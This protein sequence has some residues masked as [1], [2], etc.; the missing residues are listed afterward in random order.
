MSKKKLVSLALACILL[1]ALAVPAFAAGDN[2]PDVSTGNLQTVI[3]ANYQPAVI[4]VSVPANITAVLNPLGLPVEATK[5][6]GVGKVSIEDQQ[7]VLTSPLYIA[8][9][10]KVDLK[11]SIDATTAVEGLLKLAA[12]PFD[13]ATAT[14]NQAYVQLQTLGTGDAT[15]GNLYDAATWMS[16]PTPGKVDDAVL[17]I[18]ANN[19]LW[20]SAESAVL[21]TGKVTFKPTTVLKKAASLYQAE[22]TPGDVSA[23][24]ADATSG[25]IEFAY[26]AGSIMIIRLTGTMAA[27][28]TKPWSNEI[29]PADP[30]LGTDAVAADKLTTTLVF[31]FTPA[32]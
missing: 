18:L 26:G 12:E 17:N 19:S 10:S 6:N 30:N 16:D 2:T 15:S 32:A 22:I 21:K 31:T 8:N 5:S 23:G 9:L 11:V 1:V 24:I 3:T 4:S 13:K 25:E 27:T 20:A 28:P 14:A 7:I 29:R